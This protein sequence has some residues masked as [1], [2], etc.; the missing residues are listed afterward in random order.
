MEVVLYQGTRKH[1]YFMHF[2]EHRDCYVI[3]LQ[4][5]TVTHWTVLGHQC[6][7]LMLHRVKEATVRVL[8]SFFKTLM[9]RTTMRTPTLLSVRLQ[10]M[11]ELHAEH[12]QQI[13]ALTMVT[14]IG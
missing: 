1:P 3:L 4:A 5:G 10:L 11:E 2:S 8:E 14:W 13:T 6:V 7:H 12:G 9:L